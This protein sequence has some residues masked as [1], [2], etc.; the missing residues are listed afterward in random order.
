M[1]DTGMRVLPLIARDE[2]AVAGWR[3]HRMHRATQ[4]AGCCDIFSDYRLRVAAVVRGYGLTDRRD[5]A[6]AN[7]RQVHD[8]F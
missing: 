6:P 3:C 1:R 4:T 5:E 2:D 8:V 7:S